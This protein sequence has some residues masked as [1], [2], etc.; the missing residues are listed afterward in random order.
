MEGQLE[1]SEQA[2]CSGLNLNGISISE[3]SQQ[4][5]TSCSKWM[6]Q[7]AQDLGGQI[8]KVDDDGGE[9]NTSSRLW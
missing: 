5:R 8:L 9:E 3:P 6:T 2:I 1:C 7:T 4:S